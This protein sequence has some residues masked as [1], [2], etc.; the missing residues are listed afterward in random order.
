MFTLNNSNGTSAQSTG[1]LPQP[2]QPQPQ[3]PQPT[4]SFDNQGREVPTRIQNTIKSLNTFGDLNVEALEDGDHL[5]GVAYVQDAVRRASNWD[6]DSYDVEYQ[7][8]DTYGN[9]FDIREFRMDISKRKDLIETVVVIKGTCKISNGKKWLRINEIMPS[10]EKFP[11]SK[12]I[13]AINQVDIDS[14]K[15]RIRSMINNMPQKYSELINPNI[16]ELLVFLEQTPR[17]GKL[18]LYLKEVYNSLDLIERYGKAEN[19]QSAIIILI[20]MKRYYY[21]KLNKE[22][23][24]SI[25]PLFIYDRVDKSIL[26]STKEKD[27]IIE[28]LSTTKTEM[29]ISKEISGILNITFNLL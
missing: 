26:L 13:T 8:I 16:E 22:T 24:A 5:S 2:P 1:G 20:M 10:P 29:D 19:I 25:I 4:A 23:S 15:T 11:L 27:V 7:M 3:P 18:G 21:R 12:F 6:S 9:S 14:Y 28:T 17:K